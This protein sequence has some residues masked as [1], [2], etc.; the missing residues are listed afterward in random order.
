MLNITYCFP[1]S[2]VDLEQ[3]NAGWVLNHFNPFKTIFPLLRKP[4]E[5]VVYN[6]GM[7]LTWVN[8]F[9]FL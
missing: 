4:V 7:G 8:T 6:E 9:T 2:I 3:V 5:C 1:A